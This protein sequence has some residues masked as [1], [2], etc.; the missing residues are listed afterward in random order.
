VPSTPEPTTR[1]AGAG[2]PGHEL[3]TEDQRGGISFQRVTARPLALLQ[4]S[5]VDPE[6]D[7]SNEF[8][9]KPFRETH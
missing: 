3:V 5:S 9:V 2:R 8:P 1:T 4:F 7:T 6:R